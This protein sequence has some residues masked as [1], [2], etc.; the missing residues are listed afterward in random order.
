MTKKKKDKDT[1]PIVA[2]GVDD[3]GTCPDCGCAVDVVVD[4]YQLVGNNIFID[5]KCRVERMRVKAVEDKAKIEDKLEAAV[6]ALDAKAI[7]ARHG[8]DQTPLDFPKDE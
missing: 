6:T 8:N 5:V 2:V 7:S 3:H 4:P 1:E